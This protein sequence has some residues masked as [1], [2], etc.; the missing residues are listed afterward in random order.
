MAADAPPKQRSLARNIVSE[1]G[2][3]IAAI[4]LA[5]IIFL[6]Y[7]DVTS[8]ENPYL[9]IMAYIILPAVLFLG[10]V[11][12]VVGILIER[13]K[14]RRMTPEELARYPTID[15]NVP[16]T[17]N[18]A[19]ISILAGVF[20]VL[21]SVLG[22]YRAYHYTDS[23]QFCGTLCHTVMKPEYTAYKASPH[24]RVGCVGCHVGPGAG[25]YVR[26][27]L[28]GAYQ[29]YSVM[30]NKYPR[31][32]HSPVKNLRPSRETCEQCHWPEK[33]FGAQLKVFTHYGYDETNTP[34]ETRMLIKTGGGSPAAG[35]VAG[36]HWHMFNQNEIS[37]FA[38]DDQRQKIEWVE[39]KNRKTGETHVYRAQDTKLTPQQLAAAPKR[40]MD[41]VDC[42]NRPTHIY[43]PPDRSVDRA[44]VAGSIDKSLPYIKAQAVEAMT[45]D[46]KTTPE[47]IAGIAKSLRDF[48]QAKYPAV[49]SGKRA[50]VE[51]AVATSQAIFQ[52]T[53]F[54]EMNVDWR[55]HP[56]NVGHFYFQGCFRCHDDQHV[57]ERGKAI[58]KDCHICHDILSEA[59]AGEAMFEPPKQDFQHPVDLG[60]LRAVS[61][62]D[63]H[64]GKSM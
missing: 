7:V 57:D 6:I 37:Y 35:V 56:D 38:S 51:Q 47:A 19:L 8:A 12:F 45:K 39:A 15:L 61:C 29:L 62:S 4:A 9:G 34:R 60:D 46:Y 13:R 23:D 10:I 42:H 63:C 30:F 40:V 5:N 48:Y 52:K 44:I 26:S 1:I 2:V 27:K 25:W 16:R 36:I 21:V 58:A 49:W 22:S 18:I 31:P 14:R 28:S 33:F 53:R 20:F 59:Q 17:R 50:A 24:A 64:T 43:V 11:L 41:C 55:T 54:P 32:I 3:I